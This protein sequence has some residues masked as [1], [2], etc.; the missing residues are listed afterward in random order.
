MTFSVFLSSCVFFS[1][2]SFGF[3]FSLGVSDFELHPPPPHH[4]LY[5]NF[6][7][8][9]YN[10]TSHVVQASILVT[11]I[12]YSLSKNRHSNLY[13][14]LDGIFSVYGVSSVRYCV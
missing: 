8:F 10:V 4:P 12:V 11:G 9:A 5:H 13:Q 7:R 1:E 3:C 14:F 2:V 6:S